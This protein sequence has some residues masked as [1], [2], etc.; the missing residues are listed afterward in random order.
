MG[1]LFWGI[2]DKSLSNVIPQMSLIMCVA[3]FDFFS[4]LRLFFSL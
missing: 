3:V 2:L 4:F 1:F